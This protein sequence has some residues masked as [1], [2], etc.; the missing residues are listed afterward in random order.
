MYGLTKPSYL[1]KTIIEIVKILNGIK[2]I[3]KDGKPWKRVTFEPSVNAL[4]SDADA[5]LNQVDASKH[6][7]KTQKKHPDCYD[8]GPDGC[9]PMTKVYR[10]AIKNAKGRPDRTVLNSI[11]PE[12]ESLCVGVLNKYFRGIKTGADCKFS[13]YDMPEAEKTWKAEYVPIVLKAIMQKPE[14]SRRGMS[15]LTR[16]GTYSKFF[17]YAPDQGLL[18]SLARRSQATWQA[19]VQSDDGNRRISH[20]DF[21]ALKRE[22][23]LNELSKFAEACGRTLD[24]ACDVIFWQDIEFIESNYPDGKDIDEILKRN[25]WETS[26]D[27]LGGILVEHTK[28]NVEDFDISDVDLDI[29]DLDED[30]CDE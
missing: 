7:N 15:G 9:L 24:D 6:G 19:I 27:I 13:I 10:N 2:T 11:K 20:K 21:V 1:R 23:G 14:R 29:D 28:E 22:Q 8:Q 3:W 25:V 5:G 4:M 16:V 12:P 17:G 30:N 26:W 18:E